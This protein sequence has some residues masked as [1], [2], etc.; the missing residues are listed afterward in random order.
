MGLFMGKIGQVLVFIMVVGVLFSGIPLSA[1]PARANPLTVV[2]IELPEEPV[3]VDVSPGSD[4]IVEVEGTVTCKKYG[5]DEVKVFLMAS[6]DTGGASVEPPSFV[7][8]GVSGSEETKSFSVSTRVPMGYTSSATPTL[9]VSGHYDQGGLRTSI[10]PVSI[11][12]I[13]L[14]Y[15]KIEVDIEDR[16]ITV[17]SGENAKIEFVVTNVGNGDD[18]IEIDFKNREYL[19]SKGFNLPSPLEVQMAEN[20]NKSISLEIGAPEDKSGGYIAEVS[21]LSK[22]S[23]GSNYPEEVIM[24][25]HLKVT[26][27]F[28]GQIGSIITSPL[29][30]K[31]PFNLV[32][33]SS[34]V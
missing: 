4:G 15:Y 10:Q 11:L 17:K 19:Q 8:S 25:I 9:T 22:G 2:T 14:Q 28:G 32:Y 27:S 33:S 20:A 7:F 23:I 3:E 16:E 30:K 21:I 6:S 1:I 34:N 29:T 31:H 5:P 13:I 26:S 18:I 24:S 12:I